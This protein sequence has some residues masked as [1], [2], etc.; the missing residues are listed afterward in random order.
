[1]LGHLDVRLVL[2]VEVDDP[3]AAHQTTTSS[4]YLCGHEWRINRLADNS[5]H[6]AYSVFDPSAVQ[7]IRAFKAVQRCSAVEAFCLQFVMPR[8][9]C[10]ASVLPGLPRVVIGDG[11]KLDVDRNLAGLIER[12]GTAGAEG[13]HFGV[14]VG[15][16]VK[17]S[18][19]AQGSSQVLFGVVDRMPT[20]WHCSRIGRM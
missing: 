2:P 15:V 5:P 10:L 19:A 16:L 12:R 7:H 6:P 4:A 14:H 18:G 13:V 11:D 17:I 9:F 8:A 1:M 20:A 3:V